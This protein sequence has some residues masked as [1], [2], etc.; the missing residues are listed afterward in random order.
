MK[1][2]LYPD[3]FPEEPVAGITDDEVEDFLA[4]LKSGGEEGVTWISTT[5]ATHNTIYMI[6]KCPKC[7]LDN[8]EPSAFQ[9]DLADDL[10]DPEF[11]REYIH[12]IAVILRQQAADHV[13][14][15]YDDFACGY[16]LGLEHAADLLDGDR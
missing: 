5:C 16:T 4:D 11:C 1:G 8:V 3:D 12:Q 10:K 2:A 7:H 15:P 6:P 13:V 14:E 9:K